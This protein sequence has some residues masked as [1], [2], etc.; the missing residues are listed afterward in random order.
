MKVQEINYVY[1]GTN[2]FKVLSSI[3]KLTLRVDTQLPCILMSE[4]MT[5]LSGEC[6]LSVIDIPSI[7]VRL[8]GLNKEFLNA[9]LLIPKLQTVSVN[10]EY[11]FQKS[12]FVNF[13]SPE[14]AALRE[15]I[16]TLE[17]NLE[18]AVSEIQKRMTS[19]EV[20]LSRNIIIPPTLSTADDVSVA[21]HIA[22]NGPIIDRSFAEMV[23]ERYLFLRSFL[24][25]H[26][27]PSYC[28]H[29]LQYSNIYFH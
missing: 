7:A 29:W 6:Y 19:L 5:I 21:F 22:V 10:L 17:C 26:W 14:A 3:Q 12:N 23:L 24:L 11:L 1:V 13:A 18:V 25:N 2:L 15:S 28:N 20:I 8:S 16:Y 9:S 4:M 27:S